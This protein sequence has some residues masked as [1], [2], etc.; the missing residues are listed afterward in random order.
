MGLLEQFLSPPY[1]VQGTSAYALLPALLK[2]MPEA[3]NFHDMD[4]MAKVADS[5]SS[6]TIFALPDRASGNCAIMRY[7]GRQWEDNCLDRFSGRI[8]YFPDTCMVHMHHRG[9]LQLAE[10]RFH[11]IRHFSLANLY[12]LD[13][14]QQR[15]QHNMERI[16][17]S[18]VQRKVGAHPPGQVGLAD[19][20]D[21]VYHM[22]GRHHRRGKDGD[23][24]SQLWHDLQLLAK[25]VNCR[26]DA[27]HWIHHCWDD[28]KGAPCCASV[29]ESRDKVHTACFNA[30][31]AA[32]DPIPAESTW[33]NLLW[34]M[35][36]T[37]LRRVVFSVGIR[38]FDLEPE[39]A[40]ADLDHDAEGVAAYFDYLK[41][42]RIRKTQE[43]FANDLHLMQLAVLSVAL[44]IYDRHLLYEMVGDPSAKDPTC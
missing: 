10:L 9:K 12:R 8:L 11:T 24:H 40:R 41:Q 28:S 31:M 27:R 4:Q 18:E 3:F 17:F 16:I 29:A 33:T 7:W 38:A 15:V 2:G 34:N 36:R 6:C 1:Q 42:S 26:L 43:Y 20:N 35:K 37:L 19:F 32:G 39:P 25:V 23:K 44:D 22:D 14:V 5:C 13:N 30:M 21:V